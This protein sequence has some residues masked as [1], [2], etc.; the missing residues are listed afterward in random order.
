MKS[1]QLLPATWQ[2]SDE[3]TVV[4]AKIDDAEGITALYNAC[5]YLYDVDEN[6]IRREKEYYQEILGNIYH[7]ENG[8]DYS[9]YCYC[10]KDN[11]TATVMGYF[12]CIAHY[13]D[14]GTMWISAMILHPDYH[15]KNIGKKFMTS[16]EEKLSS[17]T[18][19]HISLRVSLKNYPALHFWIANGFTT[20]IHF[21]AEKYYSS[22]SN[23]E[24]LVLG[25]QLSSTFI[26]IP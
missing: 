18:I 1:E 21:K 24:C 20:I 17:D 22:E 9:S 8:R 5:H 11:E 12:Q 6:F 14:D 26:Q 4:R 13:P 3:W 23:A 19:K 7:T 15:G 25:K 10:L 2:C 16:F